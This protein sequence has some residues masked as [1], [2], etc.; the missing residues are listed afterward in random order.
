MEM[1][2]KNK[3][4]KADPDI[5]A[6]AIQL[7]NTVLNHSCFEPRTTKNDNQAHLNHLHPKTSRNN[8]PQKIGKVQ[9]NKP[10]TSNQN[11]QV[12]THRSSG[13]RPDK[14]ISITT[15]T[16]KSSIAAFNGAKSVAQREPRVSVPLPSSSA[17]A[18]SAVFPYWLVKARKLRKKERAVELGIGV[19]PNNSTHLDVR[20]APEKV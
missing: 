12:Q 4:I 14:H 6:I 5:D 20:T 1:S 15:K 19:H 13:L 8:L 7:K 9:K 11:Q 18:D 16:N 17:V 3:F 2:D 10:T